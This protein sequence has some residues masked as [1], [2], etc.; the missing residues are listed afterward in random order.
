MGTLT[1]STDSEI[2]L[3]LTGNSQLVFADSEN[4]TWQNGTTL[5][6]TNWNA[7]DEVRFGND[8][9]GLSTTQLSQIVF[10]NPE[11]RDAGIYRAR[12]LPTGE[13]VPVPEPATIIGCACLLIAAGIY[14]IRRRKAGSKQQA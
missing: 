13:I 11:G 10:L 12:M 3:G 9:S 6:L 5:T 7:S 1:L 8:S 4:E 14:E 2:D